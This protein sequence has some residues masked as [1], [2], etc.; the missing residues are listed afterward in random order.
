MSKIRPSNELV[1]FFPKDLTST[2]TM[3]AMYST[4]TDK[5][6]TISEDTYSKYAL[7][8][9]ELIEH[10]NVDEDIDFKMCNY[11]SDDI[12]SVTD[13]WKKLIEEN[14]SKS[15]SY[16]TWFELWQSI[17]SSL[18]S[19]VDRETY[20]MQ[21][22]LQIMVRF[23][24][25]T[26]GFMSW[27]G[28]QTLRD[29]TG[30]T[31]DPSMEL[32]SLIR[33]KWND[34][35]GRKWTSDIESQPI[36][37]KKRLPIQ[38]WSPDSN[39]WI[40]GAVLEEHQTTPLMFMNERS[41]MQG[42]LLYHFLG[43]GKSA[44]SIAISRMY[45]K[46]KILVMVPASLR[47]NYEKEIASFGGHE[48]RL[49]NEWVFVPVAYKNRRG[50]PTRIWNASQE[51]QFRLPILPFTQEI[52]AG[53]V[54][55]WLPRTYP[56]KLPNNNYTGG[57]LGKS[58]SV[59][60]YAVDLMTKRRFRIVHYNAGEST[61][62]QLIRFGLEP[63]ARKSLLH[64]L[65]TASGNKD[66]LDVTKEIHPRNPKKETC[67]NKFSAHDLIN[68]IINFSF[69]NP[70]WNPMNNSLVIVDESHNFISQSMTNLGNLM[71]LLRMHSIDTRMVLLSGTPIM[72]HPI[73]FLYMFD[74]MKG[75]KI[76]YLLSTDNNPSTSWKQGTTHSVVTSGATKKLMVTVPYMGWS[77]VADGSF[78]FDPSVTMLAMKQYFGSDKKAIGSGIIISESRHGVIFSKNTK[79]GGAWIVD[80]D[81]TLTGFKR[82]ILNQKMNGF[83]TETDLVRRMIQGVISYQ[84]KTND[85]SSEFPE[86]ITKDVACEMATYQALLYLQT[87]IF[88]SE[89]EKISTTKKRRESTIQ[90]LEERDRRIGE[91][92]MNLVTESQT[93][94]SK[95]EGSG[96]YR[97]FSR[98]SC[99]MTFPPYVPYKVQD[100]S[101]ADGP[102]KNPVE[103]IKGMDCCLPDHPLMGDHKFSLK[104]YSTKYAMALENIRK[105]PGLVLLYTFFRVREG[106]EMFERILQEQGG[107]RVKKAGVIE[108]RREPSIEGSALKLNV[109]HPNPT[110]DGDKRIETTICVGD[111]LL[112][113][114]VG[115]NENVFV[116]FMGRVDGTRDTI[117]DDTPIK[118]RINETS[119]TE[120]V[121]IK[122]G[123][124]GLVP[125][126]YGVVSGED[127]ED[128]GE[129][130][131]L[132]R[133]N[134]N[135]K[136]I[137]AAVL[138]ITKAG[139][140]GLDLKSIRQVHVMEPFWNEVRVQQVIGRGSRNKSHSYLEPE[141]RK[142]DN[143]IYKA[144]MTSTNMLLQRLIKN[145]KDKSNYELAVELL[146][147]NPDEIAAQL[148]PNLQ[149]IVN[150]ENATEWSDRLTTL[151][152][153]FVS[154]GMITSD[155]FVMKTSER[156]QVL[157]DQAL[158][159]F[160]HTSIEALRSKDEFLPRPIFLTPFTV[161]NDPNIAIEYY[162]KEIRDKLAVQKTEQNPT[163]S[164]R[165]RIPVYYVPFYVID[166]ATN[167]WK[168]EIM[169]LEAF[170]VLKADGALEMRRESPI[171]MLVQRFARLYEGKKF[172]ADHSK[173]MEILK[174]MATRYVRSR[175]SQVPIVFMSDS[176]KEAI[177]Q[178]LIEK[179]S[180][181]SMDYSSGVYQKMIRGPTA[182]PPLVFKPDDSVIL[183]LN[184]RIKTYWDSHGFKG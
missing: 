72:N 45:P 131:K 99:N 154:D 162:F 46:R 175:R 76:R 63:N 138:M 100:K 2:D 104:D 85:I 141:E 28:L 96:M 39:N 91:A 81:S 86:S 88:E 64:H 147:M 109:S 179:K 65:L 168:E 135:R 75:P 89:R 22:S 105:S 149:D 5:I 163:P 57:E 73:E 176:H 42:T 8:R 27:I 60:N 36:N 150:L 136:G 37:P 108:P 148:N 55:Y 24:I 52:G 182:S 83:R 151:Y 127:K 20:D 156:K 59:V 145:A 82:N 29:S 43:K 7:T 84:G 160:S 180:R 47:S 4:Q 114:K 53:L 165:F 97:I 142:V 35:N 56:N 44:A 15:I 6:D 113:G 155:E 184:D 174:K 110:E 48:Y 58:K 61:Y 51:F 17:V 40:D 103:L 26:P 32:Y 137:D 50:R 102:D 157:I 78:V 178:D 23:C 71:Y 117:D 25:D 14:E 66:G 159:L 16:Q 34:P 101:T 167:K 95:K 80:K 21:D 161:Y 128:R 121:E 54:G 92:A 166:K 177:V 18:V 107:R 87:R 30:P 134:R 169:E 123:E 111:L 98:Q 146:N 11:G 106:I 133:S 171:D 94:S 116:T 144:V 139:A 119:K 153:Q 143:F 13:S 9:E 3:I 181:A 129:L 125:F 122:W 67:W 173:H 170:F 62:R 120:D 164:G 19:M 130:I 74:Y 115:T 112:R 126:Q 49:Q 140:E 118:L 33:S 124:Y 70:E 93:E 79:R 31:I 90:T 38:L 158:K 69:T 12:M 183:T 132:M 68:T 152:G 10:T 172:S 41:P 1:L 77:N